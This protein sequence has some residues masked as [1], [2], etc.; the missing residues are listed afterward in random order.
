VGAPAGTR[1]PIVLLVMIAINVLFYVVTVAQSGNLM[2]VTSGSALF[3]AGALVPGYVAQG[4]WWRLV[5]SG[6]L[7][8][9]LLHIALNMVALWML[10]AQLELALGRWRFLAVYGL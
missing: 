4:E 1:R 2:D 3:D 7:H 9:G 5:L 8:F 10:G 6:F